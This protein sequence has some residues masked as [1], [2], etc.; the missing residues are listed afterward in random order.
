MPAPYVYEIDPITGRR[1]KVTKKTIEEREARQQKKKMGRPKLDEQ[2]L[3]STVSITA[4]V[5][6]VAW[7]AIDLISQYDRVSRNETLR[8]VLWA[9]IRTRTSADRRLKELLDN[10]GIDVAP[11]DLVPTRYKAQ[12]NDKPDPSDFL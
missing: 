2:T 3:A 12:A 11:T 9:G 1:V 6:L 4:R 10:N 8:A 7:D 5:P